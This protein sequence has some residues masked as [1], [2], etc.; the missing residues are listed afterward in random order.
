M[1]PR[2]AT[3]LASL[4]AAALV[5]ALLSAA[6]TPARADDGA[7]AEPAPPPLDGPAVRFQDGFFDRL[8]GEWTATGTLMGKPLHHRI[9]GEWTLGHQFL[10]LHI[11][12]QG[13]PDAGEAP[14]EAMVFVGRDNTS[15]RYVAH[16]IDVFGGRASETLGFGHPDDD[17]FCV[18]AA[19]IEDGWL[20]AWSWIRNPDKPCH[21]ARVAPAEVLDPDTWRYFAGGDRWSADVADAATV[22]VAMDMTSVHRNAHI[23]RLVAFYSEPFSETVSVRTAERPQGPWSDAVTAFVAEAPPGDGNAYCGLGHAELA[24]DGGR[25]EYVSYYRS[26]GDWEGEI[27]LVEVELAAR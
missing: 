2:V 19:L 27:R 3:V 14:Y 1:L 16:W 13:P 21:L 11:L 8:V 10:L 20:W 4:P 7:V 23:G 5:A 15:E 18:S 12:D 24:G 25:L 9:K 22:F 17:G 6:P 26:T